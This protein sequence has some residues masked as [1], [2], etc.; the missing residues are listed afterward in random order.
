MSN[1]EVKLITLHHIL[2]DENRVLSRDVNLTDAKLYITNLANK[3]LNH[4]S[5]KEYS[6]KSTTTEVVSLIMNLAS[7][8]ETWENTAYSSDEAKTAYYIE[9]LNSIANRLLDSQLQAQQRYGAITTIK[10]GSLIQ[11]L[12]D[13][14]DEYIFIIA[15]I[16]HSRFVDATELT[17]KIGLSDDDKITTTLKTAR[18]HL[19][20]QGTIS[21]IF[22]SDESPK[23]REYWYDSFLELNETK[24]DIYNTKLAYTTL[25]TVLNHSLSPKHK[26]DFIELS[27]SLNTYFAHSSSFS[28]ED[29]VRFLL[30]TYEPISEELNINNLKQKLI[31]CNKN[32]FDN[33]FPI[34]TKEIKNK[35]TNRKY[36][37]NESIELKIKKPL[38]DTVES[39]IYA[40]KLPT[41]EKILIINNVNDTVLKQFDFKKKL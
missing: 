14:S 7:N 23:I 1:T 31:E 11:A 9:Y 3:I 18:F 28:H 5:C 21:K 20:K 4:S 36:K 6:I 24:S 29:C 10:K 40:D 12:L 2:K 13:K 16:D 25:N 30:E 8:F 41:G 35:L 15:L 22:L 33:T 17:Y 38:D 27:N 39:N 19:S 26:S 32:I 37:L 34:D